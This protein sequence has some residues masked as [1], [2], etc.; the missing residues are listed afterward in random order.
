MWLR[1]SGAARSPAERRGGGLAK[2]AYFAA[3]RLGWPDSGGHGRGNRRAPARSTPD[4]DTPGINLVR[5]A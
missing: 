4:I 5:T 2:D 1:A 3:A